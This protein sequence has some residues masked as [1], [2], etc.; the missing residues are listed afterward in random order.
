MGAGHDSL[1]DS[2]LSSGIH[3]TLEVVHGPHGIPACSPAAA[4]PRPQLAEDL[5]VG[6]VRWPTVRSS[7]RRV[8]GFVCVGEPLGTALVEARQRALLERLRRVLVAGNGTLRVAGN[9]LVDPLDPLRRVEQ[10]VAQ[11][12]QSSGFQGFRRD[13][14]VNYGLN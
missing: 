9:R 14:D 8:K 11:C 3:G 12:D 6:D 2:H 1:V 10:A 4:V 5:V 7:H 13:R